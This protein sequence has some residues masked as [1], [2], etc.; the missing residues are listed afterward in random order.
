MSGHGG[1]DP[2]TAP[3][4]EVVVD[5]RG[6][7]CPV[8]VIELAKAVEGS[9]PGTVVALF[10]DDPTSKVDVPVWC[11]MRRQHLLDRV[12]TPE[13]GWRFRVEVR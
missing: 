8:P 2:P 7:S 11:R 4:A 9:E 10:S 3:D 5:A 6:R 13:G 1:A 12:E